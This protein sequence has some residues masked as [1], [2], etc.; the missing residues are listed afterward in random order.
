MIDAKHLLWLAE[1]SDLG[2]LSRAAEKLNVTQPTLTRAVQVIEARVGGKVLTRERHGV[3]PTQ[4]GE[5]LVA[6]GRQIAQHRN[7]AED[8]I[9]LWKD[10]L[11]RDLRVGV[12]PMLASSIMG[13]FFSS[14]TDKPPKYA[15]KVVSATASRLIERLNNND[16]D[17]VLAPEQISLLQDDL[18]QTRILEDEL[19]I[20][21]GSQNKLS[22]PDKNVTP[23][24]LSQQSW[25]SVGA[26][27]GIYGSNK[28][29]LNQ[30]GVE[31]ASSN[32]SFTGDIFMAIEM[33]TMTDSLCIL[34]KKLTELSTFSSKL[35]FL[36]TSIK[37]PKRNVAFWS[38]RSDRD[39]PDFLDFR[40]RIESYLSSLGE[41]NG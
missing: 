37:L 10:G 16:L 30:L 15:L 12:G 14:L 19:G 11:E 31:N 9:D 2:S 38:R 26:L 28:E 8:M 25:I 18:V 17:V 27:S 41:N 7:N 6:T 23:D 22:N 3:R 34:P 33:L 5:R 36:E 35:R 21:V 29:V 40:S 1:I 13:K 39:R 24:M 4:I 20:F 32:I